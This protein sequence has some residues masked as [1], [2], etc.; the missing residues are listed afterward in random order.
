MEKLAK[1]VVIEWFGGYFESD[2][3]YELYEIPKKS[4]YLTS[5]GC[6]ELDALISL[7]EAPTGEIFAV[8]L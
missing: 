4:R 2:K 8:R 6:T 5:Y 1:K 7:Y 3:V